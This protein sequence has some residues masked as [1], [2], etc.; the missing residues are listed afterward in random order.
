MSGFFTDFSSRDEK[1]TRTDSFVVQVGK[2]EQEISDPVT[3]QPFVASGIPY[4]TAVNVG[5]ITSSAPLYGLFDGLPTIG[6]QLN[7]AEPHDVVLYSPHGQITSQAYRPHDRF[8]FVPA[9]T[10]KRTPWMQVNGMNAIA[11]DILVKVG[12]A[13]YPYSSAFYTIQALLNTSFSRGAIVI[14]RIQT[15]QGL[16][17]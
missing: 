7:S 12:M 10:P 9:V 16:F 17:V 15:P 1:I 2:N 3:V 5:Q 4:N 8:L 13:E 6:L 11:K 14:T